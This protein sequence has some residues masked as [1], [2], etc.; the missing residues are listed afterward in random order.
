MAA[1]EHLRRARRDHRGGDGQLASLRQAQRR[2]V[3]VLQF[4]VLNG[5]VR[6]ALVVMVV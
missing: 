6:I 4:V 3:E 2:A 1:G 5:A